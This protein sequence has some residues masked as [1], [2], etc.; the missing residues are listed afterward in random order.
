[1]AE[2]P[3]WLSSV[4]AHLEQVGDVLM[5]GGCVSS[6]LLLREN[7]LQQGFDLAAASAYR[8]FSRQLTLWN[9]KARG[10]R[11]ILDLHENPVDITTLSERDI[12]FSI[13]QWSAL[14][15]ASRHHWG[16]EIDIYER[17][18]LPKDYHLKLTLEET[19][20]GGVLGE[21]YDWLN[22]QFADG[23]Y[24]GFFRPYY[25]ASRCSFGCEPWHLS[26]IEVAS[27]FEKLLDKKSLYAFYESSGEIELQQ[28]ILENFDRIFEDYI[29][30]V[31]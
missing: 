22:M 27:S 5:H 2:I 23:S 24:C 31:N 17:S 21:F 16:S 9:E 3:N 30:V 28:S 8:S 26:C 12:L 15:G 18:L 4:E 11:P 20:E 25:P 14:P 7:A 29:K 10:E 19:M 13:L 6:W 1:M